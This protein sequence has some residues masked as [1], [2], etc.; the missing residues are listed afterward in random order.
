MFFQHPATETMEK[1]IDLHD[2]IMFFLVAVVA[3]VS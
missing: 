3:F 2:D 1:I